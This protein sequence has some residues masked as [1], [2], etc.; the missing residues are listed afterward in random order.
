MQVKHVDGNDC[1]G[2]VKMRDRYACRRGQ[3]LYD[4]EHVCKE[5]IG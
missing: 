5:W 3:Y 2:M 4:A 1:N